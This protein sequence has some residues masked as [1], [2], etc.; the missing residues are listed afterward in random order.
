M[1]SA[2]TASRP[3]RSDQLTDL[4]HRIPAHVLLL[5]RIA[6]AEATVRLWRNT[7]TGDPSNQA[8]LADAL[9]N[10]GIRLAEV[11]R[12]K[13]A[14]TAAEEA[15]TLYRPLAKD[16][17]AAHQS[18]LANALDTLGMHLRRVGRTQDALRAR[19]ESV[20][21]LRELASRE[22]D[23]YQQRYQRELGALQQEYDQR[24]MHNDAILHHLVDPPNQPP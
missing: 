1:P 19:T 22:P 4:D 3:R 8:E 23:L 7:A 10:F 20:D 21:I 16:N 12:Y 9:H 11:G 14:A 15:V 24:G 5:T 18:D 13:D 2:S 17:P 6:I